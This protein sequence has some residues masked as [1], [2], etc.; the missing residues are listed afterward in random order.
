MIGHAKEEEH[1]LFLKTHGFPSVCMNF[2]SKMFHLIMKKNK[3]SNSVCRRTFIMTTM[4]ND[5]VIRFRMVTTKQ[6][7]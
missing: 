2:D 3:L 5:I 6:N 4:Q 7:F 1:V